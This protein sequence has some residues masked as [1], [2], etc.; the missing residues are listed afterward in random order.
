MRLESVEQV[1]E[2]LG[3]PPAV[4]ELTGRGVTAVYNWQSR[5]SFPPGTFVNMTAALKKKDHEAPMSLW[6]MDE[7]TEACS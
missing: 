7:R 5:G 2:A 1:V 3:G 4:A 6:R